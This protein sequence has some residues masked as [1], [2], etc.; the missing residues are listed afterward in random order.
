M[1]RMTKIITTAFLAALVVAGCGGGDGLDKKA[2]AD[3]ANAICSKYSKQG[4]A[5]G[6][7]DLADPKKAEDYFTK[8]KDLA[9][10]QQDELEGLTPAKDVK[11]DYDALTKATGDATTLLGD[12]ADAASAKDQKKGVELVQKL[13]PISAAVDSAAKKIGATNCA[14]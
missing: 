2:L 9:G 8:A 6:S 14:G 13:T 12:L 1:A 3:K 10:K 7:P 11:S 4:E 5:L